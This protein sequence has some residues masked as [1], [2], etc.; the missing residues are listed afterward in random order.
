MSQNID[1]HDEECSKKTQIPIFR[2]PVEFTEWGLKKSC[3]FQ[4]LL[5]HTLHA[6][7][8]TCGQTLVITDHN[9]T[10]IKDFSWETLCQ[11]PD[12]ASQYHSQNRHP[13]ICQNL[14]IHTTSQHV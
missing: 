1:F 9:T 3:L 6:P 2:A 5:E 7:G 10:Q 8:T 12:L 14:D 4:P 13:E 11:S